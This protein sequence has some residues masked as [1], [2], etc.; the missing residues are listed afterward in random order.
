MSFCPRSNA[1]DFHEITRRVPFIHIIELLLYNKLPHILT[2]QI[3]YAFADASL[4]YK[5][6]W[7]TTVQC[8]HCEAIQIIYWEYWMRWFF[9]E[10]ILKQTSQPAR[11]NQ[12]WRYRVASHLTHLPQERIKRTPLSKFCSIDDAQKGEIPDDVLVG[13]TTTCWYKKSCNSVVAVECWLGQMPWCPRDSLFSVAPGE[14]ISG[15]SVT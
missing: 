6:A 9:Y 4:P 7:S 12:L 14:L 13:A 8:R 5:H 1:C 3:D 2:I 11:G 10:V 15:G